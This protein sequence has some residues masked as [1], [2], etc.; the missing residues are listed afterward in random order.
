[1]YCMYVDTS[2]TD[3][4]NNFSFFFLEKKKSK[5]VN[6]R[7]AIELNLLLEFTL[8]HGISIYLRTKCLS[9]RNV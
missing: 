3:S 6:L 9:S 1:M 4:V 7:S 2:S 8:A 5:S